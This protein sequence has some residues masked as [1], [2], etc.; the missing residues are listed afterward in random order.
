MINRLPKW[1]EAGGFLL[2]L[3]AGFINAVGVLGL[4]H[5]VVSHLTGVSTFF[6][7]EI[8]SANTQDI[9][10]LILGIISLMVSAAYSGLVIRNAALRLRR[11]YSVA[12]LTDSFLLLG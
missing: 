4:A 10:H 12:R 9:I 11:S 3:N 7:V 2:A 5:Q 6:S 1:V 8:V